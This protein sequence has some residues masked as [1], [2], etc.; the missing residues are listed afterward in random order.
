MLRYI[1]NHL[2]YAENITPKLY[3]KRSYILKDKQYTILEDICCKNPLLLGLQYNA[4]E[5]ITYNINN[6][7]ITCMM[8]YNHIYIYNHKQKKLI[9]S[10][11]L[12]I[13]IISCKFIQD[14][15][16]N[17]YLVG[18]LKNSGG[19]IINLHKHTNIIYTNGGVISA[20]IMNNCIYLLTEFNECLVFD[21][22]MNE[23]SRYIH[24][25]DKTHFNTT[26]VNPI[27][28]NNYIIL[29]NKNNNILIFDMKMQLITSKHINTSSIYNIYIDE[30]D[31][32]MICNNGIYKLNDQFEL[33]H[34]I[35][36]NINDCVGDNNS[37]IA[38]YHNKLSII[39]NN[40]IKDTITFSDY[41]ILSH[42]ICKNNNNTQNIIWFIGRDNKMEETLCIYD[43]KRKQYIKTSLSTKDY[44]IIDVCIINN[45]I[46]IMCFK[47][48]GCVYIYYIE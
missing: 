11:P 45:K 10:I 47:D 6:D 36:Q 9:C 46:N 24:D 18:S 40:E 39:Q 26:I 33:T 29:V 8:I 19:F 5:H 16:N 23:I 44:I 2:I 20:S 25:Y 34:I 38:S 28:Y 41:L 48:N 27:I 30:G 31:L 13:D 35:H 22:Y 14:A 7:I 32:Y 4:F 42:G 15:D 37:Y 3:N 12:N 17:I 21:K 43:I 1:L